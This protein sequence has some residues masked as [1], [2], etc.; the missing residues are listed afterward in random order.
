[1]SHFKF[2]YFGIFQQHLFY[3]IDLSGNTV[4]LQAPGFKKTRQIEPYLTLFKWIFVH[5]YVNVAR[6]ARDVEWDFNCYFKHR[7]KLKTIN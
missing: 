5:S 7:A 6:F 1:M 2:C 4:W 3:K